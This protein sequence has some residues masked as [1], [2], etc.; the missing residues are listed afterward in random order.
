MRHAVG[1]LTG[2]IDYEVPAQ[3]L[4]LRLS[5]MPAIPRSRFVMTQVRL[6][7]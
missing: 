6:R 4:T 7:G 5:R 2:A 3:D 1:F